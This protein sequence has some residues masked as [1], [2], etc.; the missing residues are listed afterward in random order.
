MRSRQKKRL[1]RC[2][3]RGAFLLFRGIDVLFE[4]APHLFPVRACLFCDRAFSG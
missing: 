2:A 4:A 1:F 3:G